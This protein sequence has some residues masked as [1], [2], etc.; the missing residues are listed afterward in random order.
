MIDLRLKVDPLPLIEPL[1]LRL[2]ERDRSD[3]SEYDAHLIRREASC[4]EYE[5]LGFSVR[6]YSSEGVPLDGDVL[7]ILP[8]QPS[9]HRLIRAS[10]THNTLLI[11][12]QCDQLCVMCSQPPKKHHVDFFDQFAI[13][14]KLAPFGAYIGI[15]G[16]EPLL[17]KARLFDFLAST[18]VSRPDLRFHILTNAQHFEAEDLRLLDEIGLERVLWGIPLYAPN[19]ELH[20]DL[21]GKPGAFHH[22]ERNL[23]FLMRAGASVELRTVVMQQNWNALPALANYVANRLPFISVWA[24]MQLERIGYGRMNWRETFK[25]TSTEFSALK[26]AINLAV[27]RGLEVA[28]YNF[29]LCSVPPNYRAFAPSTISDWKR[30]YLDVCQGC[31]SRSA[32]GGFFEWYSHEEGFEGIRKI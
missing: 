1:V 16:G 27:A 24:L 6:V 18:A 15:S 8:G 13:A 25:D 3:S 17:H 30:K 20:D 4:R 26:W 12:E 2:C 14:A 23:S 31:S 32:C 29:P 9:A 11:T 19:A 21:V 22:L 10:S 5:Y 7:M 28:L